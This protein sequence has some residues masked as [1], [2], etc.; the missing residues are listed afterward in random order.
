MSTPDR[1]PTQTHWTYPWPLTAGQTDQLVD[2]VKSAGAG[3]VWLK[4]ADGGSRFTGPRSGLTNPTLAQARQIIGRIRSSGLWVG[5]WVYLYAAHDD[6][7]RLA[8]EAAGLYDGV[9]VDVEGEFER[10]DYRVAGDA[11]KVDRLRR[12]LVELRKAA[13][14][15]PVGYA[16]FWARIL[17]RGVLFATFDSLC[18][19]AM[20]QVYPWSYG[21]TVD[22]LW[23]AF[24]PQWRS[25]GPA[26]IPLGNPTTVGTIPTVRH[27]AEL[28]L[29]D[30]GA[31]SWWR[32]PFNAATR[33]AFADLV[34]PD[35][36]TEGPQMAVLINHELADVA[37][38]APFFDAPGG[39]QIGAISSPNPYP[40]VHSYG[41]PLDDVLD[42][43][44]HVDYAWRLCEVTTG[45]ETGHTDEKLVFI[46]RQD[47]SN[48][49]PFPAPKTQADIDEAVAKQKQTDDQALAAYKAGEATRVQKAI[50]DDRKLAVGR[51]VVEYP[52]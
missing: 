38:G 30:F 1:V 34:P 25:V 39:Q 23:A 11:P 6:E 22:R 24:L 20:P 15:K 27:Y 43:S 41:A 31:V 29:R 46:R 2:A 47:L 32:Y 3:G 28:A 18:D 42:T 21:Y 33:Q 45:A 14:G 44:P 36:S 17:H 50:A 40:P 49:R 26:V 13:G 12:Y 8:V 52:S 19:F 48:F 4:H 51:I 9:C 35:T 7:L 16:P 10:D 5:A 37:H